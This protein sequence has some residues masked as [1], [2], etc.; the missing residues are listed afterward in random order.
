[1]EKIMLSEIASALGKTVDF[2]CEISDICTDTRNLTKGCVFIAIKGEHFDAHD[3]VPEAVEQG[4]VMCITEREIPECPCIV[5]DDC[6]KAFLETAHYYRMKFNIRLV[7][8]TGSVG[9]TTTK[10][11]ISLVL[12]KKY[13]TLKTQG[14]LNNEIGLPKTLLKLDSE[15][16]SAVIEMG[17]SHFG[18]IHRLS[19]TASPDIAVI[20]NIGFSHIENL[21]TQE[22]ILKAK[23]EILDGMKKDS[24]LIT[25][26]D[27]E[28]LYN[29]KSEL[30][31]P[32]FTFGIENPDSDFRAVNIKEHDSVT[33]FDIIYKDKS[34]HIVLTAIGK[35]NVLNA[36]TAFAAGKLSGIDDDDVIA[37]AFS[38]FVPDSLRQNISRKKG[39]TIITDCYN[40]SPDSMKASLGILANLRTDGRKI[41]VLG[42]M[43]ELGEM[44]ETLH[45]KV[46]EM[47]VS[48]NPDMLF[49]YGEQSEYIAETAKKSGIKTYHSNNKEDIFRNVSDY[50]HEGDTV[51]FKA[52]R[53]MKL[54]EII[55]RIYGE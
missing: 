11:M 45:R 6:R 52:S 20:T 12:S 44:S 53:G 47:A 17:M 51:L 10:E 1:M 7:G 38:E 50:V 27:D 9:K 24:P 15:Y 4:A 37:T 19:C 43:L 33:E 8:V 23:L 55:N 42:D 28:L 2:D 25:N 46:G 36:L 22:G 18:E 54:E 34:I 40:A 48:A 21:R 13:R 30:E 35:H 14:N 16:Q 39:Q 5:V 3:F 41:A 31:R 29:L 49:C 32:V 26:A